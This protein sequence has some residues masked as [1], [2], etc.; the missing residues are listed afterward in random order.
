MGSLV[1]IHL[2]LSPERQK[3]R[4]SKIINDGLTRSGILY[5]CTSTH[6]PTVDV[7]VLMEQLHEFILNRK[8]Q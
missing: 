2:T 1:S 8:L 4:M 7:T 3:A 6:M 5:S